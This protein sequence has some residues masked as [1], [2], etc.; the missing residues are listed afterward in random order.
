[1]HTKN[2][3]GAKVIIMDTNGHKKGII[4][5]LSP[6]FNYFKHLSG[7]ES[8]PRIYSIYAKPKYKWS[9]WLYIT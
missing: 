6:Y 3:K 4:N 7:V 2:C 1:M 9:F 5:S 8:L